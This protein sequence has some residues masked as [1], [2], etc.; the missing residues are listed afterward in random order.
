MIELSEL[1]EGIYLIANWQ[2]PVLIFCG[3][4]IGMIFG[5]IPGLTGALSIAILLPFTFMLSPL[6]A[7]ILLTSVYTGGLTGGGITAV[8]INTPGTPGAVATTYDGYPMTKKGMQNE[9]LGLQVSSSVIGGIAGYIFLLLFISPMVRIALAFGPSEMVFLTVFVIIVIGSIGEENL[10][11][12]LMVGFLGLIMG[13][14]GTSEATGVIRGT[15]GFAELED[16][17]PISVCIIGMFAIPEF[18]QIIT[19]SYIAE[20]SIESGQDF[21]KLMKGVRKTFSSVK[22]LV[23]SALIGI[24]MGVLPGVG[25]TIGCLMSY[26]QASRNAG[27]DQKFGHG[28]PEGIIAAETANNASE[29]GAM[30]ILLALGIPGSASTAI[31]VSAFMLHGLVPGPRLLET[32]GPL[33]YGLITANLLQMVILVVI[34]VFVAYYMS[35][36]IFIPT[37]ILVPCLIPIMVMGAYSF[38]NSYFDVYLF[39]IFGMVGWFFRRNDFSLVSFMI[40][41]I[42]GKRLDIEVYRYFALFGPDLSVFVKRPISSLFLCLI[43]LI[44]AM[45]LFRKIRN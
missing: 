39:F 18:L 19:R 22:T 29:G 40:G 25:S 23:R 7:L 20:K 3:M 8:L 6:N 43:V 38:R 44:L 42:M 24:S 27:P 14:V 26:S 16:G 2:V 9:A 41:L 15:L 30:A 28:E 32:H 36:I 34:A 45:N 4:W 35:R 10:W 17:I 31:L 13:T 12:T 5:V 11:R 37:R 33:V 1:I 21:T